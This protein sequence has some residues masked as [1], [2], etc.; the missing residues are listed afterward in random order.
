MLAT[1]TAN[2]ADTVEIV[3]PAPGSTLFLAPELKTQEVLLRASAG[4]GAREVSFQVNGVFAGTSPGADARLVYPLGAGD[5]RV[6]VTAFY[7]DGRS[8]SAT[9]TFEVKPK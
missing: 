8:I 9:S 4:T 1:G 5:Y 7:D 2:P 6:Q 3:A